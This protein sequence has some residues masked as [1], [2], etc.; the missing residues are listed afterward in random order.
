MYALAKRNLVTPKI[1]S[2]DFGTE[3]SSFGDSAS[4][5]CLVTSGDFPISVKW[6]LN[7]R[8][9]SEMFGVSTA[10]LGK[11]TYALTIDSVNGKHAGNYTCE[12]TNTAGVDRYSA[13]LVVNG[14]RIGLSIY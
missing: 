14:N 13:A 7:E 12:A 9:V 3:P 11:R 10:K 1:A 5:Q 4:V 6:L 2:F 8:P